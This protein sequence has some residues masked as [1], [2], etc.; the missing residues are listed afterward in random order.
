M[1]SHNKFRENQW[2]SMKSLSIFERKSAIF[3][4]FL[5]NLSSN[6]ANSCQNWPNSKIRNS[7]F[8]RVH[9]YSVVHSM[10]CLWL[11]SA[12]LMWVNSSAPHLSSPAPQGWGCGAASWFSPSRFIGSWS[13]IVRW[14]S[15][16]LWFY[17]PMQAL[18][19][20]REPSFMHHTWC[21]VHVHHVPTLNPYN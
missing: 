12:W 21:M 5:T 19:S 13:H 10:H 15:H 20:N 18:L 14:S 7:T 9:V 8:S 11:C 4:Y 17:H 6:P 3:S 2:K 16:Y 1:K